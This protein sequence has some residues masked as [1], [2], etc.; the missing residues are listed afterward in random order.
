MTKKLSFLL[1]VILAACQNVYAAPTDINISGNVVASPCTVDN[2]E[3]I[4]VSVGDAFA[5]DL[6]VSG[7]DGADSEPFYITLSA[8]PVSTTSV[9]MTLTGTSD[10]IDS[11][12]FKS[13]GTAK[14]VS[15]A[16]TNDGVSVISP[17]GR[18]AVDL[19]GQTT[20]SYRLWAHTHSNGDAEPGT[21]IAA[22]QA[23]F[24]YQ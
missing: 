24:T 2:T 14:N 18:V 12:Y 23:S 1:L 7:T 6:A 20:V 11:R 5:A 3:D 15:V 9:D 21:V 8:C 10:E 4:N 17:G 13:T 19:L 16:I 22:I